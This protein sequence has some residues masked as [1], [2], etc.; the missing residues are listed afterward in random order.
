MRERERDGGE[1]GGFFFSFYRYRITFFLVH[2][3]VVYLWCV[4]RSIVF[5][6]THSNF[7]WFELNC[8]MLK[9]MIEL[10]CMVIIAWLV[11]KIHLNDIVLYRQI[12][13]HT[14]TVRRPRQTILNHY[15]RNTSDIVLLLNSPTE[16]YL[17][18]TTMYITECAV[19]S[20]SV[21]IE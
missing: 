17:W 20:M 1:N 3:C 10:F 12:R 5:S 9:K 11:R 14:H 2:P 16:I 8:L 6:A 18:S 7:D 4:R 15:V 21:C 13:V 19:L